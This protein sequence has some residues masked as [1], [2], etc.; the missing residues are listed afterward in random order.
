MPKYNK[1]L[2]PKRSKQ[3]KWGFDWPESKDDPYFYPDEEALDYLKKA[4]V[5][6]N[7][8]AFHKVSP[9]LGKKTERP[10]SEEWLRKIYRRVQN[11]EDYFEEEGA[12][13]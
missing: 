6:C 2:R 11:G 1:Y 7:Y 5:M 9:W 12:N 8:Y 10:L 4:L 3:P 13:L